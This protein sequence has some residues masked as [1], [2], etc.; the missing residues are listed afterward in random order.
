MKTLL[1]F[2]TLLPLLAQQPPAAAPAAEP[3]QEAKPDAK[4][5]AKTEA[6]ADAKDAQASP[7][8]T[9]ESWLTGSIDFGYR[10]R[11]DV[12]GSVPTYR[13]IVNLG[14]GPKIFGADFTLIDPKHRAFDRLDVRAYSLGDDPYSSFY[15]SAKKARTYDLRADYRNIAYY[16]AVPS[17]ADPL[18]ARGVM[19]SEQSYDTHRRFS[20]FSLDIL[21]GN[22]FVP[23]FAYDHNS[24]YGTGV[25]AFV[26]DGNEYPVPNRMNDLTNLFRG[27]VRFELRRF[28]ATLEGGGTTYNDDQNLY[29]NGGTNLGNVNT[30]VFG[31]QLSLTNLAASYGIHGTSNFSK[32]LFTANAT[33]W[34]D[35]YGQF[36]FSQPDS[37][38]RYQQLAS[39]NLFLQ[40]QILFYTSQQY[41]LSSVAKLPHTTANL[42]FELRPLRR[43]R[44]LES[45]LTDRLHGT[46]SANS[47]LTLNATS[48]AQ[49]ISSLLA[50]SIATNYSQQQVDVIFDVNP[51]LTIRGGHRYVWGDANYAVLPVAGLN[52]ADQGTLR[53]HVGIGAITYRP[54][55]KLSLT[56]EVE[57]A[58]SGG[59]YFRTSLYDYQKVRGQA[60]FNATNTLTLAADFTVLRN[61]NPN[62]GVKYNYAANQ[63]SLSLFWSPL[64]GKFGDLQGSYT[65]TQMK[66]DI[67]FLAPQDLSQQISS[68]R[69]NG[70]T[71]TALLNI[72]VPA[73]G[74]F[75]PKI[76]AGGSFYISSGSRPTS[77][78]QPIATMRIPLCKN[79]AWFSEWRYYGYGESF[80]LYEGFRT[81]LVSTG[82]RL[83]R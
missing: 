51:K 6:K 16:N 13:S 61:D 29:Q 45:W 64:S 18:L 83:T 46:G 33:S 28:H 20:S 38:V 55:H 76:T 2:V 14:S 21:P 44:I 37:D 8:P 71:A 5:E 23:F 78:F 41:L 26:T 7:V 79:V 80:Y 82:L 10:W 58:S 24:G 62:A 65:R 56:G 63:A 68:Y 52:S 81:H 32:G 9:A 75:A 70:H 74:V 22:W 19:L 12:A 77:Y 27:G 17:Y 49:Q 36:L 43:I 25:T 66:S 60:R 47:A 53:R 35:V 42:G 57:G 69:D 31:Q 15:L 59:A 39:G 54:F 30:R 67:G 4:P 73:H 1:L 50:S 34:L 72:K 11:T 40:S 3:K 48:G